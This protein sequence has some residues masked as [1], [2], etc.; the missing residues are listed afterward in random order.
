MTGNFSV[1]FNSV[2]AKKSADGKTDYFYVNLLQGDE[3]IRA[4]IEEVTDYAELAK[5]ARFTEM[6][7]AVEI[8]EGSYNGSK[9]VNYKLTGYTLKE[10]K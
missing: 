2:E 3:I 8:K 10:K 5:I 6:D 7:A 9:Y 1:Y 4:R